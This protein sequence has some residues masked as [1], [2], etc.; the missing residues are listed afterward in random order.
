VDIDLSCELCRFC[1]IKLVAFGGI[2]ISPLSRHFDPSLSCQEFLSSSSHHHLTRTVLSVERIRE[3]TPGELLPV[4]FWGLDSL[5]RS[6]VKLYIK[7]VISLQEIGGHE[8]IY[9]F[10]CHP[11]VR[12]DIQGVVVKVEERDNFFV[13]A[14][15]DG[16]GV[17]S[18]TNWKSME[19]QE[20]PRSVTESL[21]ENLSQKLKEV[22]RQKSNLHYGHVLGDLINVRGK[23]KKF[24]DNIEV[25]ASHCVCIN[26]PNKETERMMLL[27]VLYKKCYSQPVTVPKA[28]ETLT[29]DGG[30]IMLTSFLSSLEKS[31]HIFRSSADVDEPTFYV[32]CQCSELEDHIKNIIRQWIKIHDDEDGCPCSYIYD[33]LRQTSQFRSA[34][35]TALYLCLETMESKSSI[36]STAE[37]KYIVF[38]D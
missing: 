24:R 9:Y 15:D 34:E 7:D 28:F 33:R 27:P 6:H 25:M 30:N 16:T 31:G 32:T 38:D 18:C 5:F 19:R 8:G 4:Q 3:M 35:E 1:S 29:A 20:V 14:L 22:Q 13:Y 10:K 26:D 12:V 11:I 21:A 17:I 36:I 23:L 2:M 37:K